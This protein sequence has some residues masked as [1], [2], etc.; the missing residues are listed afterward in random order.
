MW[1]LINFSFEGLLYVSFTKKQ[2]RFYNCLHTAAYS[3][4]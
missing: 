4:K 3:G 2:N 1:A